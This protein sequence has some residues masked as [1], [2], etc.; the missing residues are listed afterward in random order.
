[1]YRNADTG[2]LASR[3]ARPWPTGRAGQWL[4]FLAGHLESGIGEPDFAWWQLVKSVP[5]PVVAGAAGLIIGAA[6][7]LA[8]QVSPR[9]VAIAARAYHRPPVKTISVPA[10][11]AMALRG[12]PFALLVFAVSGLLTAFVFTLSHPG[13]GRLPS[14]PWWR[15]L[16]LAAGSAFTGLLIGAA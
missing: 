15:V 3:R 10:I 13:R 2:P 6:A 1:A 11:S 9:V 5:R 7:A 12:A 16:P 4:S 14:D 8:A